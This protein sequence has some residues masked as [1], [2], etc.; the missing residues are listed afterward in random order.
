MTK[1]T[2]GRSLKWAILSKR[3]NSECVKEWFPNPGRW[4]PLQMGN[5]ILMKTLLNDRKNT[6]WTLFFTKLLRI[7]FIQYSRWKV[8]RSWD[9]ILPFPLYDFG[10]SC[11][12]GGRQSH[13]K[14]QQH[15]PPKTSKP[16]GKKSSSS[17]GQHNPFE[18]FVKTLAKTRYEYYFWQHYLETAVCIHFFVV[19]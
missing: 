18:H 14:P 9:D 10:Q 13:S 15:P 4:V 19:L 12:D 8:P 11:L 5:I 2:H 16:A 6:L 1:A 17:N 3:A 7:C